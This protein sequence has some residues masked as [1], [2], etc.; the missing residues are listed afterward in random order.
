RPLADSRRSALT[1]ASLGQR[2]RARLLTPLR[3]PWA[4]S[5]AAGRRTRATARCEEKCT[6]SVVLEPS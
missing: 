1:R 2:L 6:A 3:R 5:T 4:G